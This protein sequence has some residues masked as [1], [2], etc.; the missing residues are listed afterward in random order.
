MRFQSLLVACVLV[1]F[2]HVEAAPLSSGITDPGAVT[3]LDPRD[4]NCEPGELSNRTWIEQNVDAFLANASQHYTEYPY[5]NIQA[6]GAYLGAPNFFCGVNTWCNAGQPCSPVTLPG[7][8]ALMAIQGWNN[9]VNNL[10]LAVTYTA[11]ILSLKLAKVVDDLWPAQKDNVTPMKQFLAWVNGIL[12]AFP[13]TAVFGAVA[14]GIASATQGGNI[15][16]SGMM[17]PPSAGDQFL[18]WGDL[19]SQMG[20]KIDEYK[21]AI[22]TYAKNVIDAP[23]SDSQWGI[24]KVLSGGAFLTRDKNITQD[25]FDSWMYQTVSINAMALLMQAQNVYII[26]TFNKTDCEDKSEAILC[27]LQPSNKWTEWR[28]QRRESED[29]VPEN[30]LAKKLIQTY[31]LRKEEILKGPTDCFDS[32]DYEQLTNPWETV[33]EKG[34]GLDPI[35]LCNFNVNVCNFDEAEGNE[36]GPTD[37]YMPGYTDWMCELQGITW[38]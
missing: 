8:Y 34:V 17:V 19:S 11:T 24:N 30:R 22:G 10:N 6:L 36:Y 27:E 12:N 21:K 32:H 9:Y 25:D 3:I 5:D 20:S 38:T 15:I 33:S 4:R 2:C 23:I 13:T 16:A 37:E 28:F 7:W 14:G 26:R 35:Q 1:V 31:G 18:R 29:D